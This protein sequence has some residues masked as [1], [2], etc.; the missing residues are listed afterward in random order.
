MT[1]MI[2]PALVFLTLFTSNAD[3]Q[4]P[5]SPPRRTRPPAPRRSAAGDA[6][7]TAVV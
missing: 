4:A 1:K 7:K 5:A 3:R 6:L 2:L